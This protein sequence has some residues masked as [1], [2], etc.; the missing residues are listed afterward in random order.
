MS[1][2]TRAFLYLRPNAF[3]IFDRVESTQADFAKTW[4]LHSAY[5]PELIETTAC[6]SNG[7]A[8][9]QVHTLWPT[10]SEVTKIGG[11]GHEFEVDGRNYPPTEKQ[12]YNAD[13]AGRWRM[14][15]RP[16]EQ[17]ERQ[18]FLHVLITA[19]EDDAD[20]ASSVP[21]VE[22]LQVEGKLGAVMK[23]SS[24]TAKVLFSTEGVLKGTLELS[25]ESGAVR[26]HAL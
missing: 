6:V 13:E 9:L 10:Q 5:E 4:L 2:F 23:N 24:G 16:A 25:D 15:V 11:P 26:H 3:V 22:L 17:A 21:S 20:A 14:E 12:N 1:E 7:K 19:D 8:Q 18:Y